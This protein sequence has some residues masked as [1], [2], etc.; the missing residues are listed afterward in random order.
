MKTTKK[1]V[2]VM[3]CASFMFAMTACTRKSATGCPAW[4]KANH[5]QPTKKSV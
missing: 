3:L 5:E 2:L 1:A 4:S